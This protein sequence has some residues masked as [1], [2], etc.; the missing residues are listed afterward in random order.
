MRFK[1]LLLLKMLIGAE[2]WDGCRSHVQ[3]TYTSLIFRQRESQRRG[4]W[5]KEGEEV[6]REMREGEGKWAGKR[7]NAE[8]KKENRRVGGEGSWWRAV[9]VSKSSYYSS[10]GTAGRRL[11]L[12]PH[13]THAFIHVWRRCFGKYFS[14]FLLSKLSGSIRCLQG[15]F[16]CLKAIA[17][18]MLHFS[19]ID[20][21]MNLSPWIQ[22][23]STLLF[24]YTI[25][26]PL[27]VSIKKAVPSAIIGTPCKD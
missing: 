23:T 4:G 15:N 14:C 17:G 26:F 25:S 7:E 8:R 13:E 27:Y 16:N 10:K 2:G 19:I 3:N 21:M 5:A 1:W 9:P 12:T 24:R 11:P 18:G 22:N 6:S 20:A